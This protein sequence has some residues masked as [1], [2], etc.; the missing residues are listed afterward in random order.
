MVIVL[1]TL[2]VEESLKYWEAVKLSKFI[3]GNIYKLFCY[4][5]F[6]IYIE[7]HYTQNSNILLESLN[8]IT[9]T[10]YCQLFPLKWQTYFIFLYENVS[11][12]PKSE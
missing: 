6:C 7:F 11:K 4:I 10:K 5:E 12:I 9:G 8:F 2:K 3:Y 1:F